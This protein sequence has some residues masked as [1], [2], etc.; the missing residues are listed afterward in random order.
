MTGPRDWDK[1]LAEIDKVIASNR[2]PAPGPAPAALPAP[3]GRSTPVPAAPTSAPV[4]TRRR[5]KIGVWFRALLGTAAAVAL[6]FWPYAKSCGSMLFLY[7]AASVAVAL[8][9]IFTMRS[10]WT[11]RRGVAHVVGLLVMLAGIAFIAIE[12]LQRT[13]YSAVH[14]GWSCP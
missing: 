9:G 2:N 6:P 10:A 14:L 11:H 7:L 4:A 1:E 5:D 8:L 3:S 13:S 12:I